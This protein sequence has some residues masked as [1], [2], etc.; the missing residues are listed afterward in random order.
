MSRK[1][2]AISS[3]VSPLSKKA[4]NKH[5]KIECADP[6]EAVKPHARSS[7]LTRLV[8]D[9]KRRHR[10]DIAFD[11]W[12][13]E[14]FADKDI[15]DLPVD[16]SSNTIQ[17]E[18]CR[19]LTVNR[20]IKEYEK[21]YIPV[22]IDGIPEEQQWKAITE[23]SHKRLRKTYRSA[24]LKC[25]EDD[26]GKTIRMKLKYFLKYLKRQRDDSPLYVFDSN[27]DERNDTKSLLNEYS[28]PKYFAEDFFEFVGERRRPPYRWFLVGPKRSGTCVHVDPLG[29]SAWNTLISGRK[30]W[31]L[32]PSKVGKEVVQGKEFIKSGE[33]DEAINYFSTILP[34]IK[35]AYGHNVLQCIEFMQ[36]P[37]E[38]VF[39][40]AGWWH[41]VLNAEDTVAVT[42]NYCS[43]QNFERVWRKTR[44]GRKR[45][46]VKWLKKLQQYRPDLARLAIQWNE[47]DAFEM[48]SKHK[49]K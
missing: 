24:M 44:C 12:N 47:Q 22:V 7:K 38:T 46:A 35:K 18:H 21:R 10:T 14:G 42:Q 17:R 1:Q 30:R 13:R 26:D 20:F 4:D 45:M 2:R 9:A 41:A 5:T 49:R 39:V 33:D 28:V 27:F 19:E 36:Y 43:S 8:N 16:E 40:P 23:W 48:Y 34:R 6:L 31:V 25:G 3:N 32:F 29:T 37:G 11:A 15:C